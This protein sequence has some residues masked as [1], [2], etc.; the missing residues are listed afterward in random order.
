[1]LFRASAVIFVLS[2]APVFA[3]ERAAQGG[4]VWIYPGMETAL[5]SISGVAFGGSLTLMYGGRTALGLRALYFVNPEDLVNILE[6]N[7]LF[8]LFLMPSDSGPFIQFSGGPA[9]FFRQDSDKAV[10]ADWG[11]ISAGV[12]LGWR[13]FLGRM[14][15]EPSIRGGYPYM[16]GA[17]LSAGVRF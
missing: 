5:Y 3:Q 17:G 6:L 8:R 7:I 4:N 16:A 14:F 2:A 11:M 1:M 10:P 15:L 12:S 9:L 13:F